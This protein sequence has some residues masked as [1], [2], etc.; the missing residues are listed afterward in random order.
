MTIP[1]I[2]QTFIKYHMGKGYIC[3]LVDALHAAPPAADKYTDKI[4]EKLIKEI[5]CAGIIST[6]SRLYCDLN[7]A[8]TRENQ[9]GITEYRKAIHD[10]L[11]YLQIVDFAKHTLQTPFLHLS[12]HGMKDANYGPFAIEIGTQRG[13]SCSR[14]VRKWFEKKLKSTFSNISPEMNIVFDR[15]FKG[16]ESI[17]SHR[18]GDT[19]HYSGYGANFHTFQIELSRTLRVKYL[20]ETVKIFAGIIAEFQ[21]TFV[22]PAS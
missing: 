12:F 11:D 10:I 1:Y 16:N 4:V 15:K 14:E 6:V 17:V 13:K 8:P 21:D 5:G 20:K 19:D 7:R 22:H 9:A 3:A 2:E 18:F